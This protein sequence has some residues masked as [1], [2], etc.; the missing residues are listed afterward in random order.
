MKVG[1]GLFLFGAAVVTVVTV[2]AV[3]PVSAEQPSG[4]QRVAWLQGCW[5]LVSPDSTTE[6]QWMAPRGKSMVGA[7]R[8]VRADSL[9]GYELIVIREQDD[10]LVYEAHPSGQPA[11]SFY[12]KAANGS[13][14][15]F[16]NLDHDFPQR[17]GY[18]FSAPD[19][20]YAWIEGDQSGELRR[21]EFSYR[22]SECAGE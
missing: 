20:L 11:A 4:I 16:E 19:S 13:N 10:R 2:V 12:E 3:A 14:V 17:I 21:I 6:E 8:T 9:V 15:V 1:A 22:R 18:R 7:S 5:E